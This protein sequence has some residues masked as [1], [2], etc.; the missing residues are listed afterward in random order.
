MDSVLGSK[1]GALNVIAAGA[2]GAG[3]HREGTVLLLWLQSP[4]RKRITRADAARVDSAY[5]YSRS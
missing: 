5:M 2:P 4:Y 1:S 3:Q